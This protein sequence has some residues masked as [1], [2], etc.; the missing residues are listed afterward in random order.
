MRRPT[1]IEDSDELERRLRED[2][3]ERFNQ[4]ER[5]WEQEDR[6]GLGPWRT[7][8]HRVARRERGRRRA[9]SDQDGEA[10]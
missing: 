5:R 3:E 7:D 4:Q 1:L 2:D 10:A 8:A 6:A 9:L